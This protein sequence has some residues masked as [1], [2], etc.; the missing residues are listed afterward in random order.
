MTKAYA[1]ILKKYEKLIL[2]EAE[3]TNRLSVK[4]LTRLLAAFI[5]M[6][7]SLTLLYIYLGYQFLLLR[8]SFFLVLFSCGLVLLLW[9]KNWKKIGHLFLITLTLLI[10]SNVL[11]FKQG[12][13]IVTV[14]YTFLILS[15]GYYILGPTPGLIYSVINIIP[16]AG[17]SSL[18]NL[19]G[20]V[21]GTQ[22]YQLPNSAYIFIMLFNFSVL[23]AVHYYFFNAFQQVNKKEKQLNHDL[24]KALTAA[25]ELAQAKTNFLS[26]MSHELRT[27]LHGVIAVTNI[28]ETTNPR[29]D[30]KEHID[31]LKFSAD[32]LMVTIN[33]I[34]DF[35]KIDAQSV[36]LTKEAFAIDLL[37]AS[38]Y[39]TFQV[40]RKNTSVRFSYKIDSRL[41][42]LSV[43]ADKTRLTQILFNLT[44]NALKF[45]N[46]GFV[47]I[48]V[49]LLE[50]TND[51]IQVEFK[52]QD[53]G[54]GIPEDVQPFLFQPFIDTTRSTRRQ[55]HGTGLGLTIAERLVS[56]HGSELTF[57][58]QE[59]LGTTFIFKMSYQ[60]VSVPIL[61]NSKQPAETKSKDN[62]R[63]LVAE[64]NHMNT[65][66][67]SK[68]LTQWGISFDCV[69]D[70]QQAVEAVIRNSYDVILMDINMPIMDG[71]EASRRIRQLPDT[72]KASVF[73]MALT[74]SV[75]SEAFTQKHTG[76][77]RLLD[78]HMLK[79]FKP[80]ILQEKLDKLMSSQN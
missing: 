23:L 30:Q 14:Q 39:K 40:Q 36:I 42:G 33:D 74:A 47:H 60:F 18:N 27:P 69:Q 62:F 45:T 12:I 46:E 6:T 5:F 37:V 67:I 28:L 48:Q 53:S 72:Q 26:T 20:F 3:W 66:V 29:Q 73:I 61:S 25:K 50:A 55:Y 71:L 43:F 22:H 7:S 19:T 10:W 59:G 9:E 41:H 56:L 80:K 75:D 8:I 70:G 52:I 15:A 4:I 16:I 49:D 79:P 32:N 13:N 11:L 35:N 77:Q 38:I 64:D 17:F 68:F 76:F 1:Y 24:T 31:I 65:V 78:D 51:Q 58:S 2:K 34:L 57:M 21:V 44:G 54:I 63:V